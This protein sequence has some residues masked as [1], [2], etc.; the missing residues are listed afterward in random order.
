[1][2]PRIAVIAIRGA[3]PGFVLNKKQQKQVRTAYNIYV[4]KQTYNKQKG[5]YYAKTNY[6]NKQTRTKS[7]FG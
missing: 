6:K 3:I 7:N 4:S 2:G 1:M 5:A